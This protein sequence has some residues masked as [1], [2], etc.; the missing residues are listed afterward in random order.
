MSSK[1]IVVSIGLPVYN[2][3]KYLKS[4]LDS[5][6]NQT[7]KN[8]ELIIVDNASC[9][10]TQEICT[11]YAIKDP[12]IKYYRNHYNVG[13]PRNYNIAFELSSGRYFKWTAHDDILA[14]EY[15]EECVN[16]LDS[17]E[18]IVLC[19]S[20]VGC[21]DENGALIGNYDNRTLININSIRPH[22]RFADL[23]S[24]RNTCWAI[25]GVMRSSCL[26]KTSLHGDYIDG[27]RNLL[28]ELGLMGR[29]YEIPK[30]LFFRREHPEAYTSTYYSKVRE[31]IDY[32]KQLIWWTGKP[33]KSIIVL[34]HW[35]NMFEYIN[36]INR[37]KLQLSDRLLCYR[38][39][40][41]WFLK[42]KG[43]QLMRWDLINE[44]RLRRSKLRYG[45]HISFS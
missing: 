19:H 29:I 5:I 23:I 27:D 10:K 31:V 1:N 25:H 41:R 39:L 37:V 8:Y 15:L 11:K 22:E 3:E 30:H 14:R 34:P 13:G 24:Q 21:I 43:W 4:A 44:F 45:K 35:K 16:V 17:D 32:R 42:G 2:G 36:S 18:G 33:S 6:L 28:A 40:V 7:Y 26:G 20:R 9:D 38:E 12:R